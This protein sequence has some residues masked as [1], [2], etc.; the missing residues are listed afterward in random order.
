MNQNI[1]SSSL[2]Y[3]TYSRV[4]EF[5][6]NLETDSRTEST[7]TDRKI[8]QLKVQRKRQRENAKKIKQ[9]IRE[10]TEKLRLNEQEI[11]KIDL[12]ISKLK[13]IR[14]NEKCEINGVGGVKTK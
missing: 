11:D 5:L 8:A 12:N 3:D 7:A 13:S 9:R 1:P 2:T 14:D 10:Q 6:K 4:F